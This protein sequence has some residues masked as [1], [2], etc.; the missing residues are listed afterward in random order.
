MAIPEDITRIHVLRAMNDLSE[1]VEHPFGE[2]TKY[3]VVD[4]D[5]RYLLVSLG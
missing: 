3:E 4:G 5:H 2:P 1:G